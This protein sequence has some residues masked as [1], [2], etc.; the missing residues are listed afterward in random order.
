VTDVLAVSAFPEPRLQVVSPGQGSDGAAEALTL[1][2]P[3]DARRIVGFDWS[4]DG[5]RLVVARVTRADPDARP[6]LWLVPA[7]GGPAEAIPSDGRGASSFPE[8]S[9]DGRRIAVTTPDRCDGTTDCPSIVRIL[10]TSGQRRAEVENVWSPAGAMAMPSGRGKRGPRIQTSC[11][12][13][14]APT[15]DRALVTWCFTV[16]CDR[17]S[18]R[19]P[20][21]ALP[22]LADTLRLGASRR[23]RSGWARELPM[24]V[25]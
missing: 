12:V 9:P 1:S 4:P 5:R 13:V 19:R 17:P 20:R 7:D 16:E 21:S 8:W 25:G 10:A 24:E 18:A 2:L 15:F 11:A 3:P 14:V 6:T 23:S 22:V